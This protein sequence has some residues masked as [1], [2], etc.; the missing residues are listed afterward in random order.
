MAVLVRISVPAA[1]RSCGYRKEVVETILKLGATPLD[2]SGVVV[3]L[4]RTGIWSLGERQSIIAPLLTSA[5]TAVIVNPDG[6]ARAPASLKD[7]EAHCI[8]M[9]GEVAGMSS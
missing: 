6:S 9:V 2:K 3:I 4:Q 1:S 5:A 8:L 7:G